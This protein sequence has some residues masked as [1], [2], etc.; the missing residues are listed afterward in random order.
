MVLRSETLLVA[1]AALVACGGQSR[2]VEDSRP[3]GGSG[4]GAGSA[5]Q[6]ASVGGAGAAPAP[7]AAEVGA[8]CVIDDETQ[9]SFNGASVAEVILATQPSCASELCLANHFQGRVSC[10]YGQTEAE[11]TAGPRCFL[12]GTNEPVTVRVQAQLVAR[13]P[14]LA[15][16]CSCRCAGPG[17]GP[18]CECPATTECVE[19]VLP[20][21]LPSR[22]DISGSYC[23][24]PGAAYDRTATSGDACDPVLMNCG[25]PRPL[26][27]GD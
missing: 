6:S 25:A 15:S 16:T 4:S 8:P 12:P 24:P 5:G 9:P 21:G 1:V 18:F 20:L 7:P 2:L 14:A 11:A 3:G 10:P 19:V 26:P 27:P 17:D 13:P 23:I 22:E